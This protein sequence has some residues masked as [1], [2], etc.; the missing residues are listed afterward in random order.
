MADNQAQVPPNRKAREN[1]EHILPNNNLPLVFLGL[2]ITTFLVRLSVATALPSIV[3]ELGGGQNYS[4]VENAYLIST[5]ALCPA[6]GKLSD[7]FGRKRILYPSIIIF[8]IGSALCGTARSMNWLILSRALQGVGGGAILQLV[9]TVTSDIVPLEVRGTYGSLNA[10]TWAVAGVLGPVIG[11]ALSD[12][13]SWRWCFWINLPTGGLARLVLFFSLNLNPHQGKSF[14]EHVREFDFL[15]VFLLIGGVL[16][17]M[18]GLSQSQNG[19]NKPEIIGPLVSGV[20]ALIVALWVEGQTTRSPIIPPRLFR[21]RTTAIILIAE[22]FHSSA[23]YCVMFYIPVY[24][25]IL[26]ASAT[27]SGLLILPYSVCSAIASGGGAIVTSKMGDY[28]S[29]MWCS[30]ALAAIGYGLMSMLNQRSSIA[31]QISFSTIAG[32]GIGGAFTAPMI[33]LQAAMPQKD[34]STCYATFMLF[35]YL[36][37]TVGL[38]IGQTLWAGVVQG[39][40]SKISGLNLDISSAAL[41]NSVRHIQSIEPE[42]VKQQVIRAYTKGISDI[43]LLFTPILCLCFV[44]TLFMKKY[45]LKRKVLRLGDPVTEGREEV[46]VPTPE[47]LKDGSEGNAAIPLHTMNE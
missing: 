40:L 41:A 21:T 19:W 32:F 42:I 39:R 36:G 5:A 8:L 47:D 28:R 20:V 38:S 16:S 3:A 29:V 4:W 30:Y 33:G 22:L 6:Y 17:L 12:H 13:L 24:F 43:W 1:E 9:Q 23:F 26:G 7:V 34:V 45:S 15:G 14:E 10:A 18:M 27:K 37:S 11:G 31:A 25:Q 2:M 35:R 44:A 46:A